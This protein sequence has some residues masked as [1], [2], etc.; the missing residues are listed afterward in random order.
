MLYKE[1]VCPECSGHGHICGGDECSIWSKTCDNCNGS[2]WTVTPMTNSDIIKTCNNEQ[3]VKV[4]YN[5][6][7]WAIY[8]GGENNRLLNDSPEDLLLWLNKET[9]DIDLK[10]IFDFIDEKDYEHPYLSI[11]KYLKNEF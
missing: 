8:S 9:D 2:G 5:L 4:Y 1:T 10:S 3:L 11:S 7:S 6:K